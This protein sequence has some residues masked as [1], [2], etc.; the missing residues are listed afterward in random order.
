MAS[1][2][3][4]R[5]NALYTAEFKLSVVSEY[6]PGVRGHGFQALAN[7]FHVV[8]G[9]HTVRDWVDHYDG[10]IASL[11][12]HHAGGRQPIIPHPDRERVVLDFVT[13]QTTQH[14]HVTREVV[15]QHIEE[16]TGT[17]PAPSTV[18][19]YDH[20]FKIRNKR[21][22]KIGKAAGRQFLWPPFYSAALLKF[23]IFHSDASFF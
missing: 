5:K 19:A 12:K 2:A 15:A 18:S 6:Q 22:R 10:T 7:K 20:E 21:I 1:H 11:E 4:G 8:G 17:R 23:T 16:E 13:E 3:L 14:H 9:P